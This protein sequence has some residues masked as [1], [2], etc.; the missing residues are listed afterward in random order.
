MRGMQTHA[1]RPVGE[2]ELRRI[3]AYWRAANYLS[4][5]QIYLFDNPLVREPLQ[6][7]HVKVDVLTFTAGVWE[8]AAAIRARAILGL[9]FLGVGIDLDRN[10]TGSGDRE[11][12][13]ADGS[14][15][16]LVVLAREDLEMAAN[17][18][19]VLGGATAKS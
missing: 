9:D 3:D 4:V 13:A 16:V 8:N 18:R 2:A 19:S 12:G 15:R 5:G 1:R 17:V 10:G 7:D 14:A 6:A 11:I